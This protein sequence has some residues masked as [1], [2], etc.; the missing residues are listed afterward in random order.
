MNGL[1]SVLAYRRELHPIQF[2]HAHV[3][4]ALRIW[5]AKCHRAK[6]HRALKGLATRQHYMTSSGKTERDNQKKQDLQRVPTPFHAGCHRID[7]RKTFAMR[8]ASVEWSPYCRNGGWCSTTDEHK[9]RSDS[10]YDCS[11]TADLGSPQG[12]DAVV[13]AFNDRNPGVCT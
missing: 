5:C 1:A 7:A 2:S 12:N 4:L 9:A 8:S 6:C 13:T 10:R 3:P 11:K